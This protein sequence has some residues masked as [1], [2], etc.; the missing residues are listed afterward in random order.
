MAL[1]ECGGGL[2]KKGLLGARWTSFSTRLTLLTV[3]KSSPS[4]TP[5]T[6]SQVRRLEDRPPLPEAADDRPTPA[7]RVPT[8]VIDDQERFYQHYL[9]FK[10]HGI[11]FRPCG[12]ILSLDREAC[13]LALP[14]HLR[15]NP[16]AAFDSDTT[17]LKVATQSLEALITEEYHGGG[18]AGLR[19]L[20]ID[21]KVGTAALLWYLKSG[22]HEQSDV[23]NEQPR[24]FRA[25]TLCTSAEGIDK[26]LWDWMMLRDDESRRVLITNKREASFDHPDRSRARGDLLRWMVEAQAYWAPRR[27]PLETSLWTFKQAIDIASRKI[28]Y[29]PGGQAGNW[30]EGALTSEIAGTVPAVW[31]D[32]FEHQARIYKKGS[33]AAEFVVAIVSLFHPTPDPSKALRYWKDAPQQQDQYTEALLSNPRHTTQFVVFCHLVR[34][35]QYLHQHG[36]LVN[37]RWVLDFGRRYSP[38]MFKMQV[39]SILKAEP[40]L[41]AHHTRP[42]TEVE[43]AFGLQSGDDTAELRRL[44]ALRAL[45]GVKR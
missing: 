15:E 36:D 4:G 11:K 29:I 14:E 6:F 26:Y 42:P 2:V 20:V 21:K 22:L 32:R 8:E 9:D 40:L 1:L 28:V 44:A 45:R 25:L 5:R 24:F 16:L 30:M 10:V 12:T 37:A 27:A 7:A 31:Y 41:D 33:R 23:D 18:E 17:T 35:A 3:R 34:L 39:P 13:R 38:D 19:E 43:L